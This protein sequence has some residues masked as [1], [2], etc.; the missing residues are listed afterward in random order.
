[1]RMTI[2]VWSLWYLIEDIPKHGRCFAHT[3]QLVVKD[4]MKEVSP[5]LKTVI[6]KAANLVKYVRKSIKAS[7]I[8]DEEKRL[9]AD[10]ATRWN[11]QLTMIRSVLEVSEEKLNKLDTVQLTGYERKLLHE[12][13]LLL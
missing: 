3:L 12:L 6:A 8:L 7:E 13:C 2:L 11:S 5:H 1:M 4:G 9:Q 10:N